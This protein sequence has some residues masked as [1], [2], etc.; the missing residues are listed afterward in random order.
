MTS[1]LLRVA[2]LAAV[3]VTISGCKAETVVAGQQPDDMAAE[4]NAAKPVELPPAMSANKSFR[5]KD[6]SV[7]Y[8]DFFTGDKQATVHL[9]KRDAPGTV[10]K[11]DEAGKP[12]T[13]DGGWSLTGNDKSSS[14]TLAQPGKDAQS[15]KA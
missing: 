6:N 15:C 13:A 10:L 3:L 2:P 7:V 12:L 4:L 9:A 5:C 11:A 8:V 14:V 1:L